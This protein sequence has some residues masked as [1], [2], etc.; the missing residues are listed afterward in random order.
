M[1]KISYFASLFELYNV[2]L[3]KFLSN[4]SKHVISFETK[5]I[6]MYQDQ[7]FTILIKALNDID[8]FAKIEEGLMICPENEQINLL[9]DIIKNKK[10]HHSFINSL[11]KE[12][13]G[14]SRV[15][16]LQESTLI[17]SMIR[18]GLVVLSTLLDLA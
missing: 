7:L 16:G 6:D 1:N 8:I 12:L 18:N 4:P 2:I 11:H 5:G 17:Q 14:K 9:Q 13:L 3:I 15:I 10:V